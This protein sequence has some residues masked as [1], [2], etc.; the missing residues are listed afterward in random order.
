MSMVTSIEG[1]VAIS[2]E[3]WTYSTR[4]VSGIVDLQPR[5]KSNPD[6]TLEND[7]DSHVQPNKNL[8][9]FVLL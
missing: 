4:T 1:R 9:L 2:S 8:V 3:S 7:L 5:M 6:Q